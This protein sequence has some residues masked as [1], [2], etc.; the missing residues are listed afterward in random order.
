MKKKSF[1]FIVLIFV[2]FSCRKKIELPA[3]ETNLY[4]PLVSTTLNISDLVKDSS[5]KVNTDQSLS[6]VYS[7]E[8]YKIDFDS[9]FQ[10]PDTSIFQ[11]FSCIF[12]GG[13]IQ[14]PA[15]ATVINQSQNTK[16]NLDGVELVEAIIRS[17][18][19]EVELRSTF[20]GKTVLT[21][22]MPLAKDNNGNS[23]LIIDTLPAASP[24][25][26]TVIIKSYDLAGYKMDLRGTN[27]NNFNTISSNFKAVTLDST[28]V[29]SSDTV[30][31]LNTFKSIIPEY[32]RG[33][34]GQTVVKI[35]PD[36]QAV[37]K[38][39]NIAGGSVDFKNFNLVMKVENSIGVDIRF[40][41]QQILSS[42]FSS[43][44]SVFLTG[45]VVGSSININ[46]ASVNTSVNY[47]PVSFSEY[48]IS[49]SDTNSNADEL[50]EIFPDSISTE[51]EISLNPLGNISNSNDFIY[52]GHGINV[53]LDAEIPLHLVASSLVLVDTLPVDFLAGADS[54]GSGA[55]K[56]IIGGNL[57]MDI[58]N[59]YPFSARPQLY[60][61]DENFIISD[62]IVESGAVVEAADL[63]GNYY[64]TGKKF[65]KILIPV[66]QQKIEALK[67]AKNLMVKIVFSTASQP[68]FVKI[69]SE[70]S[71]D[72][73][74][75]AD[76]NYHLGEN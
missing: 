28:I 2:F 23:L 75:V 66:D 25:N 71:V 55:E 64:A 33:Y 29:T 67:A 53:S 11:S 21:Y 41:L 20:K 9:L 15:N 7:G 18:F 62:S 32:A 40:L 50:F 16:Y 36:N 76:I 72:I 12:C 51:A 6:I 34:F 3:W 63:D 68:D 49:M 35:E 45:S 8:V 19:I 24:G 31:I 4:F 59:G 70:Y 17:G 69:Y 38:L 26:T 54:S 10:I 48:V 42:N 1:C 60:L 37:S 47:P 30:K 61:M 65:S 5:L 44:E 22:E 14:Y 52:Y 57:V 73:K 39:H 58:Y 27:G 13:G 43:G 74:V 46:R 56:N